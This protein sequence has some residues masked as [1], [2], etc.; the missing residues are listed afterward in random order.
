MAKLSGIKE[1]SKYVCKS[2][3]TLM[4]WIFRCQFPAARIAGGVWESDTEEV[5]AW[6]RR[7]VKDGIKSEAHM[8]VPTAPKRKMA[9]ARKRGGRQ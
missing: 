7:M 4:G 5:D 3:S 1:I 8:G 2:E 6:R 9:T